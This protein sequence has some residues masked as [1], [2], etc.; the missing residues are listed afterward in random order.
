MNA[1]AN[2]QV[3]RQTSRTL[4]RGHLWPLRR[5][6]ETQAQRSRIR[7]RYPHEPRTTNELLSREEMQ[8]TPP[9]ILLTN[10]AMLEYLLRSRQPFFDGETAGPWRHLVLDEAHS[11]DGV[12]DRNRNAA[13]AFGSGYPQRNQPS[14]SQRA[15]RSEGSEDFEELLHRDPIIQRRI[16]METRQRA[17]PRHRRS[18]RKPLVEADATFA[19]P[20]SA[21]KLQQ[22]YCAQ[23]P[24]AE[25]G[26]LIE[27]AGT[28][29]AK[30]IRRDLSRP[31]IGEEH[32][33]IEVQDNLSQGAQS[34][35]ELANRTDG[36]S[37]AKDLTLLIDLPS[38]RDD[39]RTTPPHPAR[40][41]YW[42]GSPRRISASTQSIPQATPVCSWPP[43]A[44]P[45]VQER[46][47]RSHMVELGVCRS[48][49]PSDRPS[50][51]VG[52]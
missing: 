42:V 29:R 39:A 30:R 49:A 18:C 10:Y 20:Q 9:A 15:Q 28:C 40:Y 4:S 5:R 27:K 45:N 17:R 21:S 19:L 50:W 14:V 23:A 13:S 8:A 7:L 43:R 41:H 38:Q 44:M 6:N 47:R 3:K 26:Q 32:T 31:S 52:T 35:K 22:A 1:L 24:V 51:R 46:G 36:S 12:Q 48:C 34:L 16:R 2:D 33:V 11:Y 25:L 37:A